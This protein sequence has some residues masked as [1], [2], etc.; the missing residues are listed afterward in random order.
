V[1]LGGELVRLVDARPVLVGEVGADLRDC[2]A[3]RPL[4]LGQVWVL[5]LEVFGGAGVEAA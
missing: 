5:G 3:D 1:Q 4:R 2:F